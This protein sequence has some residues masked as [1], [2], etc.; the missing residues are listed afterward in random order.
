[1]KRYTSFVSTRATRGQSCK[2]A[3]VLRS[4]DTFIYDAMRD[5]LVLSSNAAT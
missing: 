5:L 3:N 1:V 2:P 4:A